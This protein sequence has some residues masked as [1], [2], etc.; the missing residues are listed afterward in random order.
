MDLT[1]TPQAART[2]LSE[3][4]LNHL[5]ELI[6]SQS[7]KT[8]DQLPS[9]IDLANAFGVSKPPVRDALRH[10]A[11]FGVVDLRQGKPATVAALRPDYLSQ[12]FRFAIANDDRSIQDVIFLRRIVECGAV[13]LA[14]ANITAVEIDRL[15]DQLVKLDRAK[16]T[17][18][19]WIPL[20]AEFH[21]LIAEA[22][23]NVLI[24][25]VMIALKGIMEDSIRMLHRQRSVR[26]PEQTYQRHVDIAEALFRHDPVAAEAAMAAHF[27]ATKDSIALIMSQMPPVTETAPEG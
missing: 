22:S 16:F 5:T 26:H 6:L 13:P 11:A 21:R 12:F 20:D 10:L 23:R 15:K 8:G 3:V 2:R 1:R 25:H 18:D 24:P 17:E 7:L 27:D 14:A 9:E 19:E 4:V